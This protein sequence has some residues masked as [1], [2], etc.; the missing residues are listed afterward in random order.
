VPDD[1]PPPGF[2]W[3]PHKAA[4][5]RAKHRVTFDQAAAALA[6]PRALT[7]PD[8]AHSVDEPRE[9]TFVPGPR[10]RL[11]AIAHTRRGANVR[12]ISAR[13]ANEREERR[14]ERAIGGAAPR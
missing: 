13:W 11:L 10:D 1:A 3:D 12:I 8:A 7:G 5:N 6:H 9:L 2:E 14:Y 4:S